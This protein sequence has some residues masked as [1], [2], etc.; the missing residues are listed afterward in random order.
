MGHAK[1]LLMDYEVDKY[2][3]LSDHHNNS[4]K[5]FF[6]VDV[7]NGLLLFEPAGLH[8]EGEHGEIRKNLL[9]NKV[10]GGEKYSIIFQEEPDNPYDVYAFKI[11]LI[12][13]EEKIDIGYVPRKPLT[14]D[15]CD[16]LQF[17]QWLKQNLDFF[18]KSTFY[19][20]T[21]QEAYIVELELKSEHKTKSEEIFRPFIK[22]ED[23][24]EKT[25]THSGQSSKSVKNETPSSVEAFISDLFEYFL[26]GVFLVVLFYIG[27]YF[28]LPLAVS[29]GLFYI[30]YL[31][32][33]DL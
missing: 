23:K 11:Y 1:Y 31:F 4:S 14:Y 27:V 24:K 2:S 29:F 33:K 3:G 25:K 32:T 6:K 12:E 18:E 5:L 26:L 19:Y 8:Y 22:K 16:G 9:S 13:G 20:S 15:R 28:L 17:N 30:I 7:K 10:K 21:V